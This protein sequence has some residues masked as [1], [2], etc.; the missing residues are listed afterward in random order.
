MMWTHILLVAGLFAQIPPQYDPSH[1]ESRPPEEVR[2][3]NG[4]LQKDAILAED[5]ERTLKDA[6]ELARLSDELK[7]GVEN[8]DKNVLSLQM[9]K[10]TEEIEK[11]AKRIHD[12]MKKY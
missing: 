12:R 3:P 9:L 6:R 5:Y 2:L 11:L 7:T 4:K 8:S 10:R 1:P